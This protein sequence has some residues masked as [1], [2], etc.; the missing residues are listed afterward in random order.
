MFVY[1]SG[2]TLYRSHSESHGIGMKALVH[3]KLG[4]SDSASRILIRCSFW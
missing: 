3:L 4:V 1:F 2:Q